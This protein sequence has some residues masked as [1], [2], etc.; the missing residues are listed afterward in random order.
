MIFRYI[1]DKRKTLFLL[2]ACC[3]IFSVVFYLY[4]LPLT[5]VLYGILLCGVLFLL[6][7]LYD[8]LRYCQ[9]HKNLIQLKN[10]IPLHLH[11][12]PQAKGLIEQDYQELL[13]EF[14]QQTNQIISNQNIIKTEMIDFYTLWVHQIKTPIAA[15]SVLLQESENKNN[16]LLSSEL[17]K[18]ERYAELV[19]QYLRLEAISS[20][21]KLA[22]HSLEHIVQQAVK[23]YAPMFIHN[24]I[25]L[26]VENLD[27][28]VLT[29]EKW[30]TFVIEQLL[31]NALKYTPSG[32]IKIYQHP[33]KTLVIE[34]T[35]IGISPEDLPRVFEKG[36]TGY[37]GRMDQKATGLG[38]YLCQKILSK[39]S[40]KINIISEQD[41][42][43]IVSLDLSS[44]EMIME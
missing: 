25:K 24:K 1:K 31:S 33:E 3:I 9:K 41:R 7:F 27:I 5:A 16:Q 6:L 26:T 2:I 32:E 15:M 28:Q 30:L 29:D 8:F 12:P 37:N 11:Q 19:L 34:D 43:T 18:I 14:Y 4:S 44:V 10:S 22:P 17:F 20:D 35:G 23:K 40:H 38:L 13:N 36:F 42:G 39:L 21:L